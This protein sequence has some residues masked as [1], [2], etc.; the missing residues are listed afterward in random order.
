MGHAERARPA[1]TGGNEAHLDVIGINYYDRNQWWN[2]GQTIRRGDPEYRP[3]REI[4]MEVSARYERPMLISETGTENE[5]RPDWLAYIAGE[6]RAAIRAG[7]PLYGI[8]LYPDP[9][10]PG[11]DDD[12]HC[13]NGLWD[14]PHLSGE[15]EIYKPLADDRAAEKA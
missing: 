3:F 2:F 13:Y 5:A 1:R 12:R 7:V 4:L 10:H 15:R 6:A 9:N 14:Y 8:C 11:W